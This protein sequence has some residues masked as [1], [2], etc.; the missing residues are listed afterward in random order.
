MLKQT[1]QGDNFKMSTVI[2]PLTNEGYITPL[3]MPE[4]FSSTST[5]SKV[6]LIPTELNSVTEPKAFQESHVVIQL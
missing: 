6:P 1:M 3:I 2:M 4:R 5:P